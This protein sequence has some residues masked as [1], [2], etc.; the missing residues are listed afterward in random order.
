MSEPSGAPAGEDD[1]RQRNPAASRRHLLGPHRRDHHREIRAA[2]ARHRAAE[3]DRRI[4]DRKHRIAD[5][6]GRDVVLADCPQH[7]AR[8]GAVEEPA[9]HPDHDQ[10]EIDK[11]AVAENDAPHRV[12]RKRIR[13]DLIERRNDH[14]DIARADQGRQADPEDRQRQARRDLIRAQRQH[15]NSKQHGGRGAR[16]RGGQHADPGRP[17]LQALVP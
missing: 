14:A 7:E 8:A 1:E 3:G 15:Q 16:R 11:R 6:M 13:K 2:D 9:D 10:G 5:R 17:S 4:A 12:G